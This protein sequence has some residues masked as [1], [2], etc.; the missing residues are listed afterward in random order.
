MPVFVL[1]IMGGKTL[2]YPVRQKFKPQEKKVEEK[3]EEKISDE[4]Y[5]RRIEMLK[6]MGLIKEEK[7]E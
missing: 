4:E 7:K 2:K 3:P 1:N 5:Q 6:K